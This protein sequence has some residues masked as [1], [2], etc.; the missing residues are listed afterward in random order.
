MASRVV[1][2]RE[3]LVLLCVIERILGNRSA[4]QHD[5]DKHE[6]PFIGNV[7]R[8]T[9]RD[10]GLLPHSDTIRYCLEKSGRDG[11]A[12]IPPRMF[13]LLLRG[14]R[15]GK[16]CSDIAMVNGRPSFLVAVDGVHWHT[17]GS[18]LEN[19]THRTRQDGRVEYMYHIRDTIQ[20]KGH[21]SASD[22]G[23]VRHHR[24]L[25]GKA[26]ALNADAASE[27]HRHRRLETGVRHGLTGRTNPSSSK[28]P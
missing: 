24:E 7:M 2:P 12:S 11:L 19:S 26:E 27:R 21:H 4:R 8:L 28:S 10:G 22:A 15:L 1:H 9:G 6:E 25:R 20:H 23:V 5:L 3:Q 13:G 16:L 14:R 18:P 17:S